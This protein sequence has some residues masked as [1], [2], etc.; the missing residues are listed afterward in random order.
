MEE[1][2]NDEKK[3]IVYREYFTGLFY[4]Y[5]KIELDKEE[6]GEYIS[7][8]YTELKNIEIYSFKDKVNID[9]TIQLKK[10]NEEV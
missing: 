6:L 3:F 5:E 9:L 1:I 4:T 2:I 7:K 10:S 8:H